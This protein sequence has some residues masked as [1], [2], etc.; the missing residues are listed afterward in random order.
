M[1]AFHVVSRILYICKGHLSETL[2]FLRRM[3]CSRASLVAE[4]LFL[5]KQLAFYQEREIKPRPFR[6]CS[7]AVDADPIQ[8]DAEPPRRLRSF[9]PLVGFK[10]PAP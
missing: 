3:L 2:Q 9:S 5:R 8:T 7:A 6:R 4:V 1:S 10:N